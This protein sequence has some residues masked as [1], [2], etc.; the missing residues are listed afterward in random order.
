MPTPAC[1][2]SRRARG[3][4]K[5]ERTLAKLDDQLVDVAFDDLV[6]AIFYER[7]AV[8]RRRPAPD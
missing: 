1:P 3:L 6:E 2:G 8:L 4:R 7:E 5:R